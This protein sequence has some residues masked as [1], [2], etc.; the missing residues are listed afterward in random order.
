M[1]INFLKSQNLVVTKNFDHQ[2]CDNQIFFSH[3]G[4]GACHMFLETFLWNFWI[5]IE[6]F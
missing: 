5:V 3:H 4:K 6:F 1:T 2:D